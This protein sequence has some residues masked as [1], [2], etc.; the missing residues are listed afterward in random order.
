MFIADLFFSCHRPPIRGWNTER[1][2]AVVKF[3]WPWQVESTMGASWDS[4]RIETWYYLQRGRMRQFVFEDEYFSGNLRIPLRADSMVVVLR[5]DPRVSSFQTETVAIPGAM[6]IVAFKNDEFSCTVYISVM[7]DADK[8]DEVVDL[9]KVNHFNFRSAVFDGE[10]AADSRTADT[11]WTS[12]VPVARDG[13]G[14]YYFVL[15]ELSLPFDSYHIACT[16]E[17][18]FELA[19]AMFK[20]TGD[21]FRFVDADLVVSDVFFEKDPDRPEISFAR[22]GTSL[23]PN[24]GRAYRS[25]DRLSVYFEVYGL[26][27]SR[28]T[29][30]YDVT[31]VIYSAPEE[32]DSRWARLGRSVVGVVGFGGERDPAISQTIRRQGNQHTAAEQMTIN[33]DALRE[34]RYELVAS[35][36]D[37]TSG[38]L[39]HSMG[40]FYKIGTE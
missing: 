36:Y 9:G 17:D 24:P 21:S 3:G 23:S 4:G 33:I 20:G 14:T 8:L 18:E 31:Y 12:D 38:E 28:R 40:V 11:L 39:A 10:W 32:K 19:R 37:R 6:D 7:I 22:N 26:G 29:T 13:D 30:D 5:F 2:A 16:F 25:G 35:V 27:V 34:G 15:R 1:G